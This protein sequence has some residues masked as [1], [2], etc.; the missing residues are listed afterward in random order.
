MR[1]RESPQDGLYTGQTLLHLAI[2]RE[3]QDFIRFLLHRGA[4]LTARAVGVF[5]QPEI[6][7]VPCRGPA[8]SGERG[9]AAG[10]GRRWQFVARKNDESGC[11]RRGRTARPRVSRSAQNSWSIRAN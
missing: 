5:F 4:S 10:A 9:E 3:E 6:V 8:A 11:A 7:R 1:V 2:A